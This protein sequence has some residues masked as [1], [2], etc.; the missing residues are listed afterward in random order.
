[1]RCHHPRVEALDV[2]GEAIDHGLILSLEGS[3][4]PIPDDQ[5]PTMVAIEIL[6]VRSMMNA[7]GRWRRENLFTN[8][9]S[10]TGSPT[11]PWRR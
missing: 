6:A 8:T 7:M 5:D 1:M 3:E 4:D 11:Q 10:S 2:G 9:S